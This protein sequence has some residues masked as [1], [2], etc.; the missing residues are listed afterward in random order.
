MLSEKKI[1]PFLCHECFSTPDPLK[2]T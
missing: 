1:T 2:L